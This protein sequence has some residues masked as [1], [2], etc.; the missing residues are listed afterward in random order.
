MLSQAVRESSQK[1]RIW[2]PV[3][4]GTHEKPSDTACCASSGLLIA[5]VRVSNLKQ[6]NGSIQH[7]TADLDK[8]ATMA[9]GIIGRLQALIHHAAWYACRTCD[10]N[11]ISHTT[12]NGCH[13]GM[14]QGLSG[15][16]RK[17]AEQQV[18]FC[19]T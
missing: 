13:H 10:R 12:F 18:F 19:V 7:Q 1:L 6:G 2:S 16:A 17:I 15:T 14:I 11:A 3:E 4:D 9:S 8:H 5:C